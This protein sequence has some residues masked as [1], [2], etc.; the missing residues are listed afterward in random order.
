[1]NGTKLLF[2]ALALG[3]GAAAFAATRKW[4]RT[5]VLPAVIQGFSV[6]KFVYEILKKISAK[7][8]ISVS[9]PTRPGVD[10]PPM[11]PRVVDDMAPITP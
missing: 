7:R 6:A 10:D 5:E 3:A 2:G 1:M 4:R 9:Y 8:S 11:R